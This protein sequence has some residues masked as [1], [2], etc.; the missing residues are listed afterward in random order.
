[1]SAVNPESKNI[2][3][4]VLSRTEEQQLVAVQEEIFRFDWRKVFDLPDRRANSVPL[5]PIEAAWTLRRAAL[6]QPS[7]HPQRERDRV[8]P[9]PRRHREDKAP[10]RFEDSRR[11]LQIRTQ[12][13]QIRQ[14]LKNAVGDEGV[15]RAVSDFRERRRLRSMERSVGGVD[16]AAR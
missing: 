13:L 10:A 9:R 1:M 6:D 12:H 5:V 3:T 2:T 15:N 8:A 4:P 7:T 16:R 11:R 14:M